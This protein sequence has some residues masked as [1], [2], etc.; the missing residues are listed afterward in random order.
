MSDAANSPQG[1]D[2]EKGVKLTDLKDDEPKLGHVG[3]DAVVLVR[4]GN[5]VRAIGAVCTHY[6]GPL[7]EGLVV[8]DTIRCPWHHACFDLKTGE[9][10][11][12]PALSDVP[13]FDV[14]HEGALVRVTGKATKPKKAALANAP[15]SVV[16]I[17]AGPAGAAAVEALRRE[18]YEGKI[19]L[20]GDE[21]PGPVDRPNL[22][23]DFLMGE[24]PKEWMPLRDAAFYA[25]KNVD[26]VVGDLARELDPKAK[27]IVTKSGKTIAY[28][29]LLLATG[30]APIRL[31][32]PGADL[33]HVHV[34]RTLADSEA[35]AKSATKGKIAVVIGSSFIG[36]EA[37]ASL[38]HRDVKVHVVAPEAIPLAGV[39]GEAAGQVVRELHEQNGVVFHRSK[40]KEITKTGV[41]LEN[42]ETVPCDLVVV[43]IGVRP[44]LDL[45]RTA[46][47]KI[48]K[49]IVV[50][51]SF[52]TSDASI[53]AAGD[54]ARY[55]DVHTGEPVRI[56]HFVA[57]ERQA[58]H[59]A[60]AILGKN[61]PF[62]VP[63]FFWSLHYDL[64]FSYVGHAA[65]WD[66]IEVRGSVAKRDAALFYRKGSK[67][68]AVVTVDRD[69]LCLEAEAAME[70]GDD[71]ALEA[72]AARE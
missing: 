9:A 61:E 5:E 1:P 42:G 21:E 28:D 59:A 52:R 6:S 49:G 33:P 66:R 16:V 12:G 14:V 58:Q 25:E 17:G 70:A 23:K 65:S 39:L 71:A 20:L 4:K 40:P 7:Q 19:T 2:L 26:F 31:D 55:P 67:V 11:G 35:I 51:A 37:A 46:G 62:R 41:V 29:A 10:I 34:L 60:A 54:V 43:G 13:C 50:D 47:L 22:S 24:A 8:G 57:A 32:I 69:M 53:W 72:L 27:R 38:R 48:D 56:E 64:K 45:A 68:V 36:L 44:N 3:D 15:T 30:A 18:G 63:P